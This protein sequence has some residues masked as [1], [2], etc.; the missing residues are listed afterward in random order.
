MQSGTVSGSK[1]EAFRFSN[2]PEPESWG[3]HQE[4]PGR[5]V[6]PTVVNL[7]W[8]SGPGLS[9]DHQVLLVE[10]NPIDRWSSRWLGRPQEPVDSAPKAKHVEPPFLRGSPGALSHA[11]HPNGEKE[12]L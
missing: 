7:R 12:V 10:T 8:G 1:S 11:S 5:V 4:L 2:R 9:G 6:T 3:D